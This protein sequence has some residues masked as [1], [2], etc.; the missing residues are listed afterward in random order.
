LCCTLPPLQYNSISCSLL[1]HP[2][3]FSSFALLLLLFFLFLLFFSPN[4]ERGH[5]TSASFFLICSPSFSGL[6]F[7]FSASHTHPP[8]HLSPAMVPHALFLLFSL[9]E[10]LKSDR[11]RVEDGEREGERRER[12]N[13]KSGICH[14]LLCSVPSDLSMNKCLHNFFSISFQKALNEAVTHYT[15]YSEKNLGA[16]DNI[17]FRQADVLNF[18]TNYYEHPIEIKRV[19]GM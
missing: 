13:R 11:E 18:K 7:E 14:L 8:A 3:S 5:H 17:Q 19:C 15:K 2:H 4:S 16:M 1:Y 6:N 10:H 9:W 12:E